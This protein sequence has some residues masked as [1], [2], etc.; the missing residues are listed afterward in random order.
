[1]ISGDGGRD[2]SRSP[3]KVTADSGMRSS[4]VIVVYLAGGPLLSNTGLAGQQRF[5][6]TAAPLVVAQASPG[7]FD[8]QQLFR[9][10]CG[11]CHEDG[12]R[13]PGRGPKLADTTRS[14][15]F[16]INRIKN[17]KPGSMP[18]FGSSFNDSQI[19]AILAYIRALHD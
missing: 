3:S 2:F 18:A 12:G 6:A 8:V 14:D 9:N 4:L 15:E 5:A 11:F 17:G 1:M 13:A 7:D 10:T 16:I 19:Q